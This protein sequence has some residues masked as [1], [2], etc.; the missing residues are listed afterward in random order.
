MDITVFGGTGTVGSALVD[1]LR[2]EGANVRVVTRFAEK[3]DRFGDGVAGFV[4]D[5]DQPETLVPALKNVDGV[6]LLAANSPQETQQSLSALWPIVD[7]KPKRLIYMSS[8]LSTLAP[9]VPHAGVKIGV[10]AAIR[11]SGIDYTTLRPSYFA[12]NDLIL[13]DAL[14]GGVYP[15]PFGHT[16]VA[17]VDT[18]DVARAAATALLEGK[19]RNQSIT[20]SSPDQPNGEEAA[21]LWSGALARPIAYP[22]MTPDAWANMAPPEMPKWLVFDLTVMYRYLGTQGAAVTEAD[23]EAQATLL[24]DGPR[25]YPDFVD[26]CAR[27]WRG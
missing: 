16:H 2:T 8:L 9:L 22:D 25:R 5:M 4:A 3:A 27:A 15:V 11:T 17:R 19:G 10:E 20:V 21:D 12:Q 24:P 26:E 1:I 6:F 18:R 7:A 23:L 13:K 14:M